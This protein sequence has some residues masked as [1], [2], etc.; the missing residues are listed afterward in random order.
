MSEPVSFDVELLES[1]RSMNQSDPTFFGRLIDTFLGSS[2]QL[3]QR[4]REAVAAETPAD[5]A[6]AA[7]PLKSSSAQLGLLGLSAVAKDMEAR[8]RAGSCEGA[9]ELLTRMET[10]FE[11]GREFLAAHR[12]G[13]ADVS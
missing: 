3:M 13:G 2:E 1:V 6:T 7:H 12:L 5:I 8:G 9:A 10:E 4:L 11:S